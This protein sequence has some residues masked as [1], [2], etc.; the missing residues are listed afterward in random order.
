MNLP[1][2]VAPF[3]LRGVTLAVLNGVNPPIVKRQL[4]SCDGTITGVAYGSDA[5]GVSGHMRL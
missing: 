3:I 4:L 2:S 1:V 5:A